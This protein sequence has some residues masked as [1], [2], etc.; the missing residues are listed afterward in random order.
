[1][2]GQ[3]APQADLKVYADRAHLLLQV[4][5]RDDIERDVLAFLDQLRS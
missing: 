1:L 5:R 3:L 4:R 2:I